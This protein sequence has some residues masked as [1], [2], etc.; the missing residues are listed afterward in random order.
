MTERRAFGNMTSAPRFLAFLT[1]LF[2][3]VPIA[4]VVLNGRYL[5]FMA[6]F[7]DSLL[8][9]GAVALAGAVVAAWLIRPHDLA[10][11][12]D[13]HAVPAEAL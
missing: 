8:V 11:E 9:A 3:A 10:R 7:E 6:G 13:P 12:T 4:C 2:V 1:V 5:G